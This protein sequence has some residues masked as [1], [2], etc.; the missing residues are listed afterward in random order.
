MAIYK[1]LEY[2]NDDFPHLRYPVLLILA[3]IKF[4]KG[5]IHIILCIP[6]LS[7]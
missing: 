2:R 5:Y 4:P 1:F 6:R 7:I 3:C